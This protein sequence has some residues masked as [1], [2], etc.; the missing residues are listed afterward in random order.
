[1][2][3]NRRDVSFSE[4]RVHHHKDLEQQQIGIAFRGAPVT[5]D[6]HEAQR[7]AMGVL[8]GGMSSRLFT[9]VREKLGLAYWVGAWAES[10]RGSGMI[11][12]G[13]SSTPDRCQETY[14]VLLREVERLSQD[15][16][17]EELDRAVIGFTSKIHTQGDVTGSRCGELADDLFHFGGPRNRTEK[18]AKLKAVTVDDVCSYLNAHPRDALSVVTLGPRLLA[19]YETA[20]NGAAGGDAK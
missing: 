4:K 9:E 1:M 11:F 20:G 14:E 10:P 19:G 2:I 3:R 5:G 15:L 16:T 13:A 8:S 12:L 6:Y 17:Q 7:V 18:I